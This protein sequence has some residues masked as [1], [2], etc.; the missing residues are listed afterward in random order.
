MDKK[1][2]KIKDKNY[3]YVNLQNLKNIDNIYNIYHYISNL[4]VFGTK[5]DQ[6]VK[7]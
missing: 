2:I 1:T 5:N 4:I 3:R 6:N 7:K